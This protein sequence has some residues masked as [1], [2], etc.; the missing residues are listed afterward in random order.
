MQKLKPRPRQRGSVQAGVLSPGGHLLL[1]P[2]GRFQPR[3]T[4]SRRALS[5]QADTTQHDPV[6]ARHVAKWYGNRSS[7]YNT[8]W[9][10]RCLSRIHRVVFPADG[11]MYSFKESVRRFTV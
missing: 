8:T 10:P 11:Q 2:G 7:T 1:S 9:L 5:A 4:Q 6:T 3:R